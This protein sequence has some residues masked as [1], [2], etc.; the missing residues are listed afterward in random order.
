[1][2]EKTI[3]VP[4]GTDKVTLNIERKNAC[5]ERMTLR[6]ALMASPSD[7]AVLV[8]VV[9]SPMV[10]ERLLAWEMFL[11]AMRG[12]SDNDESRL[13]RIRK[14]AL[15]GLCDVPVL[16]DERIVRRVDIRYNA[17]GVDCVVFEV[18]NSLGV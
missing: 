15:C 18:W 1:M 9:D 2:E 12:H 5:P 3:T 6:Q 14:F 8:R 13:E 4:A 10:C 17:Q 16:L 7:R 11:P